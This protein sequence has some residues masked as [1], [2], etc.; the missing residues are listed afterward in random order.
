MN[1]VPVGDGVAGVAEELVVVGGGG[2]GVGDA[3]DLQEAAVVR[4]DLAAGV[5]DQDAFER[6]FLLRLEDGHAGAQIVGETRRP[7]ADDPHAGARA[8]AAP[9]ES[10]TGAAGLERRSRTGWS[11]GLAVG[12]RF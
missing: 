12:T 7:R 11:S 5:D 9:A 4:E 2:D 3:P 8:R 6:R 1:D 10:A